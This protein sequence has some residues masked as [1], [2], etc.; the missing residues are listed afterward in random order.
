M[1][2]TVNAFYG[3]RVCCPP[4][5]LLS[6]ARQRVCNLYLGVCFRWCHM[7]S[8]RAMSIAECMPSVMALYLHSKLCKPQEKYT[9]TNPDWRSSIITRLSLLPRNWQPSAVL[10]KS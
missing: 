7:I 3:G 2:N 9:D 1:I 10:F 4:A 5:C 6:E 8:L